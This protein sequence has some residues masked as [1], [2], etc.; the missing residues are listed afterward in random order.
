MMQD[1]LAEQF[2][3][4]LIDS[5]QRA[6]AK[7]E[8]VNAFLASAEAIIALYADIPSKSL[9][10]ALMRDDLAQANGLDPVNRITC[11]QHRGWIQDC[12]VRH[13]VVR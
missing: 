2:L 7:P 10:M 11:Q 6:D 3:S 13:E 8:A 12:T 9:R 5:F 4:R 1:I